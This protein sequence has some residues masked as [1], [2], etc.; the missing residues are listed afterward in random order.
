MDTE[1][2]RLVFSEADELPGIIIDRYGPLLLVQLLARGLDR[3][4]IRALVTRDS[5]EETRDRA[6][7]DRGARGCTYRGD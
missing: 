5:R 3:A 7:Y 4:E 6:R 2:C 1:A